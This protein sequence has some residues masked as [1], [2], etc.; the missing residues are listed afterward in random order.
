MNFRLFVLKLWHK[1]DQYVIN[2][3]FSNLVLQLW[4]KVYKQ[5]FCYN[6]M[7]F[8]LNQDLKAKIVSDS[9]ECPL[10]R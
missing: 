7:Y 4:V 9:S 10:F 2:F 8:E 6:M 5:I 1:R 3:V